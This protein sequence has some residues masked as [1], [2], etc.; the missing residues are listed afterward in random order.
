MQHCTRH[1]SGPKHATQATNI[2]SPFDYLRICRTFK[3][4]AIFVYDG[5]GKRLT[6]SKL[7]MAFD[8]V[9]NIATDQ[10]IRLSRWRL[11]SYVQT[12]RL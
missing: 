4:A 9:K 2:R 8:A 7:N 12:Q 6:R 5:T 11:N 1:E 3:R 10:R